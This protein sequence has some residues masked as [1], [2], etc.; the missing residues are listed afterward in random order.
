MAISRGKRT[1]TPYD[2]S[3]PEI[4]LR[5]ARNAAQ[6]KDYFTAFDLYEQ[7]ITLVPHQSTEILAELYDVYHSL[8][9]TTSRYWLY[10]GRHFDFA[11]E[12]H[13]KVL[14]IGSGNIPFP[15]ATH[16]ADLAV[17]DDM[18]GRAGVP[19]KYLDGKPVYE[20]DVENMPFNDKEF[21][22]VYCSHVLEHTHNPEKA[23]K[24]LMRI[25]KRGYIETPT[26][27]KDLFLNTGKVS[28]HIYFVENI[29]NTLLFTEYTPEELQ[30]LD[31]DILLQMHVN[32]QT[33][34]EKAFS[35]LIYLKSHLINTMLYWENDFPVIVRKRKQAQH[36]TA[37]PINN[38]Q[39]KKQNYTNIT[40]KK[41]EELSLM[42][43]HLYYQAFL[44]KHYSQYP[45]LIQAPFEIQ[46]DSLITSR[47]G[48]SDFYSRN[49]ASYGWKT[50]DII[51]NAGPLQS[52]WAQA[53]HIH[54]QSALEISI[55]QIR[56]EK[57]S[58]V[59][60]HDISIATKQ[61]IEA[62]RP[63]VNL[64]V[65][66]IACPLFEGTYYNG[67]DILIS[68]LPHFVEKFRTM[69]ITAYYQPLAFESSL[70]TDIIPY[71]SRPVVCSF[72]GG[73]SSI[74]TN[75]L[76]LLE[77]LATT[78]ECEFWGYGAESL[79]PASPIRAK[80]HGE[81]WGMDM[82]MTLQQSKITVNR[83]GAFAEDY[84][85]NMRL[86]EATGC[87]ALLIT[88]HKKNIEDLFIVGKEIITYTTPEECAEYIR[89][90]SA[91][92]EEAAI[93]AEAGRQR[94][95]RDHSYK[96][97]MA[98]T[99][100]WL[101]R[102]LRY[103]NEDFS[104][105]SIPLDQVSTGHTI[106][107]K[108]DINSTLRHGWENPDIPLRQRP[109]VHQELT[110]M[111]KGLPARVYSIAMESMRQD[112]KNGSA[113]LEIGCSSGY[114]SEVLEYLSGKSFSYTGIDISQT[115]ITMAES[116]YPA[117]HFA[118]ADAKNL[119]FSDSSFDIVFSS[120]AILYEIDY[121]KHIEESSRVAQNVLIY[122]RTPVCRKRETQLLKK[123]AYGI[124][125]IER[126]FNEQEFLTLINDHGWTL[127]SS[128][129]ISEDTQND[130]YDMTYTFIRK[131]HQGT[132]TALST[133]VKA[134]SMTLEGIPPF[135]ATAKPEEILQQKAITLMNNAVTF[136]QQGNHQEALRE[137]DE[138]IIHYPQ[139]PNLQYLRSLC[140][141][142]TGKMNEAFIAMFG[143]LK[144][145][146]HNEQVLYTASMASRAI[147]PYID[148]SSAYINDIKQQI[149]MLRRFEFKIYSQSGEDGTL[150]G[151][152]S[153]VG[154][155]NKKFME[156]GIGNGDECN[157]ANLSINHGWSGF[158]VDGDEQQVQNARHFYRYCPNV[159]VEQCFVTTDNINEL[160]ISHRVTGEID[161][162]S[163]DIDGNDY[164]I[165]EKLNVL[166]PRIVILEYNPTFG[167]ERSVTVP[168][169]P[170]FYRMNYHKSGYYH[171]ASLTALTKLMSERGYILIGCDSNGYNS[172][173]VRKDVAEGIF[174]EVPP[175]LAYYPA[176]PRFRHGAPEVQFSVINDLPLIEV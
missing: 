169:D 141:W 5:R 38:E 125:T 37:V 133:K 155:T 82:F 147:Q 30:G 34:R 11:I 63:Y 35:A 48:D 98:K 85:N 53:H 162:M 20:C 44:E 97:R 144:V 64:I 174:L 66:Q 52:L 39:K 132:P 163:L 156:I 14:D 106:I 114:Y 113:I 73:I 9:D 45:N 130:N 87:G 150:M 134:T 136:M 158:L 95:L 8:P 159:R 41:E 119:P 100:Q 56:Q 2:G 59:Y 4:I 71:H 36:S 121:A 176:K 167:P 51:L 168:Y 78:T 42:I 173:F 146:P 10:Q 143:E 33:Q 83:H 31:N 65:G 1:P 81:V 152:L 110:A 90:Y 86:F 172:F 165:L 60:F 12:P 129:S 28:N 94:T 55:A 140:L 166:H 69:G 22:F 131:T 161:V 88:D 57:P 21:D 120:G 80:H 96:L 75:S 62:I 137:L 108:N 104:H 122:H 7:L 77:L 79:S 109:L 50:N 16:L 117:C 138:A 116:Y 19:F 164:W 93:I 43:L 13:E 135:S 76:S 32:P 92:P 153:R 15:F 74:H 151:I 68:S 47:F 115:F 142:K 23:C 54:T 128:Y 27:G 160:L 84:A 154:T 149:D 123:K 145:A 25:A 58:I 72:V 29:D 148:S 105:V 70:F 118:V 127:K 40:T 99:S 126:I 107:D 139:L 24:E 103:K 91:H 111:Y 170:E 101:S 26:R 124:E 89:Y 112:L 18:Y 46:K 49:L 157:T 102:H 175:R 67:F 171:G 61:Y 17:S 6:M 3:A